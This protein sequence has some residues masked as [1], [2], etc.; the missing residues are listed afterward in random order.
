MKR[1]MLICIS[2]LSLFFISCTLWQQEENKI[3]KKLSPQEVEKLNQYKAEVSLGR[4]MAGRLLQF[5][6]S[7]GDES[8]VNYINQVGL[9]V[10]SNSDYPDR[11]YMFNI[12]DSNSVNAFACPGGYILITLGTLRNAKSEAELS[13]ILG[14]EIAH[15]G[16]QHMFKTITGMSDNDSKN[17]KDVT[18]DEEYVLEIRKRPSQVNDGSSEL[19][20]RYLSQSSGGAALTMLQAAKAG[21]GVLL[22]KGL[23]KELE[24]EADR[25]GVTYAIRSGYDPKGLIKFLTRLKKSKEKKKSKSTIMDKTHPK[26]SE[27]TKKLAKLLSEID[28]K[29]I[30]G[31]SGVKRFKV[32]T[33]SLPKT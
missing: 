33:K 27:R 15:V 18:S 29:K 4:D 32:H 28:A 8:L 14:H 21:M 3:E 2:F 30:I 19:L 7:Y 22:E 17:D 13:M 16:K 11:R 31:A 5:Y 24:F 10:A 12:L 23:D 26:I 1:S 6:G 20:T 25:E 9:Y